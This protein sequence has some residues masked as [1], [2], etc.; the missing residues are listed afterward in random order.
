MHFGF[1]RRLRN[2][3]S[4][5]R[6]VVGKLRATRQQA[7]QNREILFP[8]RLGVLLSSASQ[9][10]LQYRERPFPIKQRRG[11][12][13]VEG[14][15]DLGDGFAGIVAYMLDRTAPFERV[16]SICR[17]TQKANQSGDQKRTEAPLEA[18]GAQEK[19]FFQHMHQELLSQVLSFDFGNA[20]RLNKAGYWRPVATTQLL[21]RAAIISVAAQRCFRQQG[22]MCRRKTHLARSD[23]VKSRGQIK[24]NSWAL[25]K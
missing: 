19:G 6:G 18:V 9:T 17:V 4:R 15:F 10:V 14:S 23:L 7:L 1:E 11:F 16:S 2:F 3:K 25:R 20:A 22:P 21:E 5:R 24:S 8:L 13:R 12:G